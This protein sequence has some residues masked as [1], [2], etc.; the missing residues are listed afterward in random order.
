MTYLVGRGSV[1]ER[2]LEKALLPRKWGTA[3]R[4]LLSIVPLAVLLL[5]VDTA[6]VGRAISHASA[7]WLVAMYCALLG[8]RV[9]AARQLSVVMRCGGS[10]VGTA[11]A[12]FANSLAGLYSL[13]LPGIMAGGAKWASLSAATGKKALVANAIVYNR[14]SLLVPPLVA[15]TVA[16]WLSP[17]SESIG[18]AVGLAATLGLLG[19]LILGLY[20]KGLGDRVEGMMRYVLSVVPGRAGRAAGSVLDSLG[21][22]RAFGLGVHAKALALSSGAG[23]LSIVMFWS[24]GRA[25][26]LEIPLGVVIWAYA[27]VL[28]IQH[29]P[30]TVGGLGFREGFLV[31][32]L[33]G[34]GVSGAEALTMGLLFFTTT[35]AWGV[36]GGGYQAALSAGW[37]QWS[38]EPR[39]AR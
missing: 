7:L 37:A 13:A 33:G 31:L 32:V 30:I 34:Y 24:S 8:A 27:G 2:R 29:M 9:V 38:G 39:G 23:G 28:V 15:G 3:G 5:G 12:F 21:E 22:F 19:V 25:L 6:A 36:V 11:R 1:K 14:I 18:V 20:S 17:P 26:G 4:I 16:V 35:V 10:P